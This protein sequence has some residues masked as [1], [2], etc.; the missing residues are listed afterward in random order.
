MI[1]LAPTLETFFTERLMT[2]RTASGHTVA[3]PPTSEMN[4]RLCM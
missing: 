2:Q 4:S 1:S 3:A